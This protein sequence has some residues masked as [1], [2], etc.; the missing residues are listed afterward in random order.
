MS[1]YGA[2]FTGVSGLKSQSNKIGVISDNIANVNTVGFKRTDAQFETLVV[3]SSSSVAYSPGGALPNNRMEIDKQGLLLA[4]DAPTDISISGGGFFVVNARTN[5]SD[6]PMYTR[7]GSFR[8][9]ELGNFVNAAGFYLQGW[10]LDRDGNIPA[11]S[12]SLDS[13]QTVNIESASGVASATT[14]VEFGANLDAGEAV[15]PGQAGNITMDSLSTVNFGI[16]ADSIIAPD[17]FSLAPTNSITRGDQ[18]T[19]T[20]GNGLQYDYEYGGFSIGRDITTAGAGNVGDGAVDTT[21]GTIA[22]AAGAV[23]VTSNAGSGI[24]TVT[25]PNHNLINGDTVTLS[26][27]AAFDN[28]T[29]PEIN[30]TFTISNVTATTFDINTNAAG[31]PVGGVNAGDNTDDTIATRPFTGNILDASSASQ[32]FLGTTGTA[33]FTT[34]ALS[35]T[36]DT[37]TTGTVTFRYVTSSP[38]AV[39]GE[40]SNLNNLA[41]AIN[42]VAGLTARIVNGRLIVGSENAAER[43]TFANGDATGTPGTLRGIN[44]I[45]ELDLANVAQ[46][47][48][49]FSTMNSLANLVN[50]D[51]GVT[52]S[53]SNPLSNASMEIRVDD[54]L[55]TIQ[56]DDFLQT[57][58]LPIAAGAFTTES[59][60]GVAGPPVL[61]TDLFI[62]IADATVPFSVG[63]SVQLG[64]TV[65]TGNA[66]LDAVLQGNNFPV[67]A[68]TA[69]TDYVIRVPA[70][71]V[72]AAVVAG[73]AVAAGGAGTETAARANNGSLLAEMGL[74]TS[75]NSA[76]YT[77]Q[78]TGVLGP[79]YDSSGTVGQNMA[80]G[81]ITPQFTRSFWVYDAL[82]QKHDLQMSVIKT[83]ANQWAVEIF[84]M[85]QSEI[86]TGLVD[87]Q[88]VTG[89]IT[90]N[91]DGTLRSIS[92]SLSTP[93]SIN[94]TNG[95]VPSTIEFDW[96]TA[97]QPIGTPN[98]SVIG[99]TDGLSQFASDY[100][101]AFVNQNGAQVGELIG[102]SIDGEGVVIASLSN[103]ETQNLYKIPLADFANPNGLS[104]ASGNVFGQTRD[105]GE[106]NLR[107]AGTNGTGEVVAATLEA[108]NV[109]LSE[110]LT[111][112]LVAQRAYQSNT[113]VISASDELLDELNRL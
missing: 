59:P 88:V 78:S 29:A 103:G 93:I 72:T 106:V 10:A 65:N 57:P 107:E 22:D 47:A 100:N 23:F 40:F 79:R 54:P 31:V 39:A 83:A 112:L 76:A 46:S 50:A 77:R 30:G 26:N 80:S 73:G 55:D 110:E 11:T 33:G 108:S 25:F 24:V 97:G 34:G 3:N 12:A 63:Q 69:N 61:A 37:P 111:D 51:D 95:A 81:N 92:A 28:I 2:L 48:R 58:A 53:V 7:A 17:E 90:F 42:E 6:T 36:I 101:V 15:F 20:T 82:G 21:A 68:T 105:S 5:S 85:N 60:L 66:A 102:V 14:R 45:Q 35:F 13:L 87:G 41:T 75:L 98:T 52:A 8:R 64:G 113:R 62:R 71:S 67:V 84:A 44:W 104:A 91:G 43:V 38:S 89:N 86:N 56:F 16:T 74:V 27:F 109:E 9:D 4:T 19:V 96:G 32:A 99:D 70:A 18:F 1:L 94:W 49:R